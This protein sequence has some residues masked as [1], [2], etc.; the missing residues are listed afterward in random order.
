M[1][2]RTP[3]FTTA[4]MAALD[5]PNSAEVPDW[6]HLLPSAQGELRTFDGRGPYRVTD[7][8]A[9]IAASF[10]TDPRDQNGL[11]IDENHSSMLAAPKGGPSPARGKI[12]AMEARADGIWGRVDWNAAGRALLADQSYRGISPVV[13][14]DAQGVVLRI[15]NAALVNYPNLRELTALNQESAMSFMEKLAAK[16]GL[17]A[18]VTEAEILAACTGSANAEAAQSSLTEIASIVGL[19]GADGTAVVA[20]VKAKTTAQPAEVAALQA[21]L[22]QTVAELNKVK[23]NMSRDRATLFVD[24]AIKA[25]RMG[26]RPSRDRFITMH[27][28]DPAGTEDLIG[29]F[30]VL[31]PSGMTVLPP[32]DADGM[33]ALNAE[34][35]GAAKALG[36]SPTEFAALMAADRKAKEKN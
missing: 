22:T 31:S 18:T 12:V 13:I 16:L 30:E 4:T 29:K 5:L 24:G 20:A 17:P 14:H 11:V 7:P 27:M 33:V 23:D 2:Y 19:P 9:V 21:E 34:E 15:K 25:G 26:V 10:A 36:K 28:S 1:T 3:S 6:V 32:K 35:L 8:A